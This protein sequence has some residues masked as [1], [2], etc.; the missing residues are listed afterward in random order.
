MRRLSTFSAT[1]G[2]YDE[3]PCLHALWKQAG[4]EV[5]LLYS[6]NISDAIF[7]GMSTHWRLWKAKRFSLF[8]HLFAGGTPARWSYHHVSDAVADPCSVSRVTREE[9][10][11]W[12]SS[13][14][15][16][17]DALASDLLAWDERTGAQTTLARHHGLE[18]RLPFAQ[19]SLIDFALRISDRD[20][21][22][23]L[24]V[25]RILRRAMAPMLPTS[26]TRRKKRVT[27]PSLRW[28]HAGHDDQARRALPFTRKS[29][30]AR[31]PQCRVE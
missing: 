14:R 19:R 9:F 23:V 27:A 17:F 31:H 8:S 20:K 15:T 18:M 10:R 12:S 13:A 28:R 29:Q 22:N 3:L 6:G 24:G 1:P 21:V 4:K 25:K 30:C 26:M 5:D 11:H 16:Q 2:G 7:S